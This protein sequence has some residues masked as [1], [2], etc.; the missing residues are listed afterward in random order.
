MVGLDTQVF[1]NYR[2][3]RR[4]FVEELAQRLYDCVDNPNSPRDKIDWS[5]ADSHVD[6]CL[7]T[8]TTLEL[9]R[10]FLVLTAYSELRKRREGLP[11]VNFHHITTSSLPFHRK[12]VGL[13]ADAVS[14]LSDDEFDSLLS[15]LSHAQ[16][17]DYMKLFL[18]RDV[19]EIGY[20]SIRHRTE[21]LKDVG[22]SKVKFG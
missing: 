6:V 21:F 19:W 15:S 22:Y 8:P 17:Q 11:Y 20:Q 9:T 12:D 3:V 7:D 5:C 18:G 10:K 1:L 4:F 16:K 13:A 2:R 14:T